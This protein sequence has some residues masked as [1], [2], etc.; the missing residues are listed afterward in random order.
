[1]E[2]AGHRKAGPL[3]KTINFNWAGLT[4]PVNVM[5]C[6]APP[7]PHADEELG[8]WQNYVVW[9]V[10]HA[11]PGEEGGSE[12]VTIPGE[13]AVAEHDMSG[14]DILTASTRIHMQEK[15]KIVLNVKEDGFAEWGKPEADPSL[16]KLF[17]VYNRTQS[18]HNISVG[19]VCA[20]GDGHSAIYEPSFLWKEVGPNMAVRVSFKPILQAYFNMGFKV[21]EFFTEDVTDDLQWSQDVNTLP[22][23]SDFDI[24]ETP[25][26]GY[27]IKA[28]SA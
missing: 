23:H 9:K 18:A 7:L 6:F 12:T 2:A 16:G 25:Q 3:S 5:L 19:T 15:Q 11:R 10:I 28:S 24:I 17:K 22:E 4:R 20:K 27:E 21:A 1:M 26:H 14:G 8:T 13:L